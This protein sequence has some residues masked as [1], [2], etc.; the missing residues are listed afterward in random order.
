[1]NSVNSHQSL[2]FEKLQSMINQ[3]IENMLEK[4][5]NKKQEPITVNESPYE[6]FFF[7]TQK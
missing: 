6:R 3:S 2:D 4:Q 5:N 7:N 1:M